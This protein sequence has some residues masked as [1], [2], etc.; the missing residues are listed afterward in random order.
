MKKYLILGLAL[1]AITP[2][3]SQRLTVKKATVDCGR[4]V[5]QSPVKATF[6]LRNKSSRKLI[7]S[8][9]QS[10]C[11]CTSVEWP[12]TEIEGGGRFNISATYDAQQMGHFVKQVAIFSNASSEPTILTL[13]G[14]VVAEMENFTGE[15]PFELGE[16]RVDKNDLEFDNVNRGDK[17]MQELHVYN[18]SNKTCQPNLQH[19]PPYLTAKVFP[20][21][22]APGR[23][24]RI[25]ITLNSANLHSYG[26]TQTNVY[27]ASNL[28][29]KVSR[30][31]SIS[32]SAV[33]LPAFQGLTSVQ[34]QFGPHLS[35]SQTTLNL[36]SFGKKK[37]LSGEVLITNQGR[38][39]LDI[40]SMQMFTEGLRVTLPKRNIQPG[41][42]IKMK[43]TAERDRLKRARSKPRVLMITNDPDNAKVVINIETTK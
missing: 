36:G 41:E 12:R 1:A 30:D 14:V 15:Y 31:R 24:A 23:T 26:L 11:G 2:A 16:L 5:F 13:K 3:A 29:E 37:K 39:N 18:A 7:I 10:S 33:L 25:R 9:V 34:R 40:T 38:T 27:L 4:V 32:V 19:L 35:I 42:T 28:G 17:P 22:V 43:I 20:E 8:D 21:R 6:E